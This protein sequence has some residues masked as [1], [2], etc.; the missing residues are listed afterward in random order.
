[1][2]RTVPAIEKARTFVLFDLEGRGQ[3]SGRTGDNARTPGGPGTPAPGPRP[4]VL[5]VLAFQLFRVASALAPNTVERIAAELFFRPRRKA[6]VVP[7]LR[8]IPSHRFHMRAGGDEIMVTEWGAGPTV[9]LVHGWNGHTG[10]M[11]V[12]ARELVAAGFHVVAFDQPGHGGA[13]ARHVTLADMRDAVL[14]VGQR[15]RPIHAV[16]AHSLG[17]T[18]AALALGAGLAVE[19]A[20][21]IAPPAEVPFF[22][23]AF[24]A[25]LGLP[26]ARREGMLARIRA[27][28]DGLEAFDLRRLA[29]RLRAPVLVVHDREDREVPF[30]HGAAVAAAWPGARLE[31]VTGLGHRAVLRDDRVVELVAG[32][33]AAPAAQSF[34]PAS[35]ISAIR[36]S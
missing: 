5:G 14:A 20:V 11:T 21:L 16:V 6:P 24:G 15:L 33:V 27:R 1:M 23:R 28:F 36:R 18:A 10:Q 13:K 35:S 22:V 25:L 29:P 4:G 2:L 26:P 8:G 17:A 32:F 3:R 34:S 12:L 9:L 7:V 30:A 31:A 19:R